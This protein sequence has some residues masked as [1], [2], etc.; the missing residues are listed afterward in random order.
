M[1]HVTDPGAGTPAM[2][3]PTD[4]RQ[5]NEGAL[6]IAR[7]RKSMDE[8]DHGFTLVELLVVMIIIGILAAIAIP[9]FLNQRKKATETSEKADVSTIGKEAMSFYVDGTGGLTIAGAPVWTL[10]STT[11][12]GTVTTG[13][14]SA[15][16]TASGTATSATVFC[17]TVS[18]TLNGAGAWS[19]GQNG[20][21]AGTTC[22]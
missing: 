8:K 21:V 11:P 10:S 6:M 3:L 17:F 12:A 4:D 1:Y 20:L 16:N 18:S 15:S 2:G 14:L 5:R 22:P 7:I 19:Y 13:R 9:V